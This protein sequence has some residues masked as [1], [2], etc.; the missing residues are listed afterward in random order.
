MPPLVALVALLF[1]IGASVAFP[2]S[3]SAASEDRVR[4]AI[5]KSQ[6]LGPHGL[7][8]NRDSLVALSKSL[9]PDDLPAMLGLLKSESSSKT[10]VVFALAS[11]CGAAIAPLLEEASH[12]DFSLAQM[13]DARDALRILAG[14]DRCSPADR[15]AARSAGVKLERLE[16]RQIERVMESVRTHREE[17]ARVQ[18]NALKLLN[19]E[20]AKE[21]TLEECIEVVMR[22]RAALQGEEGRQTSRKSVDDTLSRNAIESCYERERKELR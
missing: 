8:Y 16:R 10:G 20:K 6:R 3:S 15:D 21:V 19:P 14:F 22:S 17:D 2:V 5:V 4:D 11:Q 12:D 9:T 1:G 7:G 18:K 13:A